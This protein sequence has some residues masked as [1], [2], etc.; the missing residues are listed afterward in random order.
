MVSL[1]RPFLTFPHLR[2]QLFLNSIRPTHLTHVLLFPSLLQPV[3]QLSI[4][5]MLSSTSTSSLSLL[6][7]GE[8]H[9][10]ANSPPCTFSPLHP[11][12]SSVLPSYLLHGFCF[13]LMFE[14]MHCT[15]LAV[16]QPQYT[17]STQT[18]PNMV[19]FTPTSNTFLFYLIQC[20]LIRKKIPPFPPI[21]K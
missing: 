20:A 18:P 6:F 1:C 9:C 13:S 19:I 7:S 17:V 15:A 5:S 3:S 10:K 4:C 14:A 12:D 2:I 21:K 8:I 11:C 16:L